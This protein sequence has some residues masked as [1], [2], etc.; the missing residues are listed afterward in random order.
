MWICWSFPQGT[1]PPYAPI[2]SDWRVAGAPRVPALHL[3]VVTF[4]QSQFKPSPLPH[5]IQAT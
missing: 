2:N 5:T 4:P 1:A 3:G